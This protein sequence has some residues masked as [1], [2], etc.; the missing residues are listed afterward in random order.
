MATELKAES[1]T[2]VGKQVK[3]LRAKG[4][5][6]AVV[7]GEGIPAQSI[8]ISKLQFEKAYAEAGES[9]IV[10]LDVD[11]KP[12]NVLIQD[13]AHDAVTG[14]PLH[15]DFYA[16][17]MDK[18]LRAKV[19]VEFIGESLAV[20]GESGI[21]V[22]VLQELEVEALPK[23]LPHFLKAD[24]S[25]LA[26]LG[27]RLFVKDITPPAGVKIL[28]DS[29]DVVVLVEAPRSEEQIAKLGEVAVAEPV[30][31]K[32]EREVKVEAKAEAKAAEGEAEVKTEGKK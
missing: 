21:L 9:T 18:L 17:R 15:A 10:T 22:K 2:L 20:K 11:G 7:Y 29:G 30:E 27:S 26:T 8:V 24:L 13:I 25:I 1:R 31:V 6:P 32:T 19:P 12:Y 3:N 5:L 23:D 16:V 14:V 4:F 28:A